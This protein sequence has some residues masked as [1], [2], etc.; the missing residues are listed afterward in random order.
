MRTR[1]TWNALT[2]K[3][4]Y[5]ETRSNFTIQVSSM[6]ILSPFHSTKNYGRKWFWNFPRKVSK[7]LRISE[8]PKPFNAKKKPAFIN[9]R[10][11]SKQKFAVICFRKLRHTSRGFP[12]HSSEHT[13]KYCSIRSVRFWE[14]KPEGLVDPLRAQ[15]V[16]EM[17]TGNKLKR[18]QRGQQQL[19]TRM[20]VLEFHQLLSHLFLWQW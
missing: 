13:W 6:A 17:L 4:F 16:K 3:R 10:N 12:F 14:F 2:A 15:F 9:F 19:V 5:H 7:N 8:F 18:K 20:I 1:L 11:H